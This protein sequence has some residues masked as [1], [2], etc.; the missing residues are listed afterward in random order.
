MAGKNKNRNQSRIE[1]QRNIGY[2]TNQRNNQDNYNRI[3][4]EDNND[5]ENNENSGGGF[6]NAIKNGIYNVFSY[7]CSRDEDSSFSIEE[8]VF[9]DLPSRVESLKD[10]ENSCKIKVGILVLF[11]RGEISNFN[12]IMSKLSNSEDSYLKEILVENYR[13]YSVRIDSNEGVRLNSLLSSSNNSSSKIFFILKKSNQNNLNRSNVL[14][15]LEGANQLNFNEFK[16]LV[17]KNIDA[18]EKN[19]NV[20][21]DKLKNK[22]EKKLEEDYT[23]KGEIDYEN[24][25]QADLIDIQNKEL[26]IL[27]REANEKKLAEQRKK[28]EEIKKQ[29]ELEEKQ[30]KEKQI[31]EEKKKTIPEEPKENEPN[32]TMIILR[33]PHSDQRAERRFYKTDTIELLYDYVIT[34]GKDIFEESGEFELIQPFPFKVYNEKSKT[35][36]E[37]KLFPNAVLQIREV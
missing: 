12:S 23:H 32:T 29:K 25:A 6:I 22:R 30:A 15:R 9:R 27:E 35:L 36:E 31:I 5:I 4:Q 21:E 34:L 8:V 7:F 14:D 17:L 26:E 13:I 19:G 20:V 18:T 16:A 2:G 11:N 28:E 3:P 33:Y 37:E 24:I 10:F 1:N